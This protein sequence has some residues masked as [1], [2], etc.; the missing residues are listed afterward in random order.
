MLPLLKNKPELVKK[1]LEVRDLLRP[2]MN[3]FY[4]DGGSIGRRYARQD[5]AGTPFCVT[6]DFDTLGEKPELKDTVTMRYRDDGKQERLKISE[7]LQLFAVQ[8]SVDV[9]ERKRSGATVEEARADAVFHRRHQTDQGR[10]VAAAG[11]EHFYA[12]QQGFAGFV[13]PISGA[14][15]IWI[16]NGGFLRA[17]PPGWTRSPRPTCA[18]L[19]SGTLLYG[20]FLLVGG[21]G[22]AFRANWAIWLAIGES[23]F[24]IPIEI[25]ELVRHR[26]P[27]ASDQPRPDVFTIPKSAC[28]S[29]WR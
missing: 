25:F 19:A 18:W 1:A 3:V 24:F 13:Q 28:S 7:L 26:L 8:R 22:L 11:V 27:N 14:G 17:S 12:G 5:E 16:R 9:R 20:L 29:C 23:A 2:R 10:V 15:C 21:T 4:D 6:I